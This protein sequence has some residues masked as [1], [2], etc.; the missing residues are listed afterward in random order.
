MDAP[1]EAWAL[2]S[3]RAHSLPA[4]GQQQGWNRALRAAELRPRIVSEEL[5]KDARLNVLCLLVWNQGLAA[6][7]ISLRCWPH[8]AWCWHAMLGASSCI[9]TVGVPALLTGP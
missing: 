3:P 6:S 1:P 7:A 9:L 8:A 5:R 4:A 2:K